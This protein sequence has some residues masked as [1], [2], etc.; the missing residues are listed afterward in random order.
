MTQSPL[1]PVATEMHARLMAALSP[2]ALTIT[3]DSEAHRGHAGHNGSGESHFTVTIKAA[4]FAG[5]NRVA[6]QRL[7]Y[8][9]L[10]DLMTTH[11]HALI[12][13]AT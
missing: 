4:A 8:E 6:K 10:G 11:I 5:L 7:V 13:Q 2:I 12:I 3:D 1:G 9:A